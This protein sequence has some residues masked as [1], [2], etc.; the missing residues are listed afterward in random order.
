MNI[1]FHIDPGEVC[2]T[3][4]AAPPTPS[5]TTGTHS[6]STGTSTHGHSTGTSTASKS[7]TIQLTTVALSSSPIAEPSTNTPRQSSDDGT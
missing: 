5:S 2:P 6:H 3:P 4:T 1:F 7:G